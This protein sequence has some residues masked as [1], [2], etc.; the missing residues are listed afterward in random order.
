MREFKGKT[1]FITGGASGIGFGMAVAFGKV[2]MDV[3]LGDIEAGALARA[4]NDLQSRGINADGV[5]ANVAS[6][7]SMQQA[8]QKTIE[9]FGKVHLLCNNAG[10][11]ASAPFGQVSEGDWNWVIDVNLHG[12]INGTEIFVPLMEAHGEGGH[13]VNTASMAGLMVMADA[14]P[15]YATKFAVVSLSEGWARSLA[16]KNI[17]VSCLCPGLVATNISD[18]NRNRPDDYGSST[19]QEI[20][21]A[22]AKQAVTVMGQ[23]LSPEGAGRR[24]LE[25]VKA[26]EFYILTQSANVREWGTKRFTEIRSA[27]D[28]AEKSEALGRFHAELPGG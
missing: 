21:E 7:Q 6:R 12:V 20:L 14:M 4:V 23:G 27:F 8:A 5:I 17:G 9:S 25:G 11:N 15:Y 19:S 16:P 24:V 10:V 28:R 1:A 13:I 18:C 26:G 3:M 22:Q 2:G